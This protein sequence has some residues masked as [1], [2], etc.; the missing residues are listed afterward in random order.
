MNKTE[1]ITAIAEKSG[2]TKKDAEKALA[3]TVEVLTEALEQG[4]KVQLTGFGIFE[5]KERAAHTGRNPATG[6]AVEIPASRT[7]VFKASKNL[8]DRVNK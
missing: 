2:L 3:A 6:E 8:K 7:P 5:A 4:D 1:L